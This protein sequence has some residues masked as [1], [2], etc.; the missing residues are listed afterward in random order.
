MPLLFERPP[1]K[2][3]IGCL[4]VLENEVYMS[5]NRGLDIRIENFCRNSI[6]IRYLDFVEFQCIGKTSGGPFGSFEV[7]VI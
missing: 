5:D 2:F 1:E 4:S 3:D 7:I 6:I